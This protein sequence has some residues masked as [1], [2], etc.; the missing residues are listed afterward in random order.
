MKRYACAICVATMGM[1]S[2]GHAADL[3]DYMAA[4][5][6]N[7]TTSPAEVA[8]NNVLALNTGMFALDETAG[9]GFPHNILAEH[10]FILG[11]FSGAGGRFILYRTGKEPLDA[12]PVPIVFQLMKST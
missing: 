2:I 7:V 8:N 4:I 9:R 5:S 11:L 3:P 6:G 10:P 1:G 12:P